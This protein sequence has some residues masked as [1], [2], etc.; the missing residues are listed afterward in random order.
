MVSAFCQMKCHIISQAFIPKRHPVWL[1]HINPCWMFWLCPGGGRRVLLWA[2]SQTSV[3]IWAW[4]TIMKGG[5][6]SFFLFW[7]KIY[8][9]W[10][11]KQYWCSFNI[12]QHNGW[13][14]LG[15]LLLCERRKFNKMNHTHIHYFLPLLFLSFI[16]NINNA[17][18]FSISPGTGDNGSVYLLHLTQLRDSILKKIN[19]SLKFFHNFFQSDVSKGKSVGGPHRAGLDSGRSEL[20]LYFKANDFHSIFTQSPMSSEPG[21]GPT[22][23]THRHT[24]SPSAWAFSNLTTKTKQH[25]AEVS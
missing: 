14:W 4:P 11:R 12:T 21:L 18:Y 20:W 3:S 1:P 23:S 15:T 16:H 9:A 13:L 2:Q 6:S 7:I 10:D 25:T 17:H 5:W 19:S 22:A 24:Q 8:D